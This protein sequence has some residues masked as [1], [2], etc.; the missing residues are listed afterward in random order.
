M[1]DEAKQLI[2]DFVQ[3]VLKHDASGT[4]EDEE[5]CETLWLKMTEFTKE[6][7]K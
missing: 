5:K 6:H 1:E 4:D 7:S 3:A 2:I